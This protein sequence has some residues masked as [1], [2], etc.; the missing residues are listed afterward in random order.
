LTVSV[1]QRLERIEQTLRNEPNLI[2]TGDEEIRGRLDILE[3]LKHQLK[4]RH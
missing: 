2:Q 4:V 3:K 1:D